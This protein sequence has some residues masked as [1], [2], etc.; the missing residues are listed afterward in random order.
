LTDEDDLF[1]D[2]HNRFYRQV[3]AYCRRRTSGDAVEDAVADTFLTAWRKSDEIPPGDQALPWLYG[4][5]F[6][7][8]GNQWRSAFRR[9]RLEEKLTS[10]GAAAVAMPEDVVVIRQ[11]AR[12]LMAALG[13]LNGTDQEVL[14]LTAW[15]DLT[16]SEIAVALGI[17]AGAVGQRLYSAKRKLAAE[18][19]RLEGRQTGNPTAQKGGRR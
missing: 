1:L 6:R 14:R 16:P 7:V 17:S 12:Q 11:E 3:Y 9:Q 19:N 13:A 15:E 8:L 18:Y 10:L 4:V 5:A 2:I